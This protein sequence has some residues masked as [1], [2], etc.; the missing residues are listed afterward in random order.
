MGANT[1]VQKTEEKGVRQEPGNVVLGW[2]DLL[3]E[4]MSDISYVDPFLDPSFY[5]SHC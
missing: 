4:V 5:S 2:S 3:L 1:S